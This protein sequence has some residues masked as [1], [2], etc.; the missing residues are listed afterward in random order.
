MNTNDV[1]NY[2]LKQTQKDQKKTPLPKRFYD[3]RKRPSP[4]RRHHIYENVGRLRR[5]GEQIKAQEMGLT[6]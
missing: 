4:K 2:W 6:E 5:Q 1:L 3:E